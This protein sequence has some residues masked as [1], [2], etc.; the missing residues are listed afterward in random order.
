MDI[1]CVPVLLAVSPFLG[2][3]VGG[4]QGL[5]VSRFQVVAGRRGA[6]KI[7]SAADNYVFAAAG[8][9]N[10]G[11]LLYRDVQLH[12]CAGKN[13]FGIDR[14]GEFIYDR[15]MRDAVQE[16]GCGFG[17]KSDVWKLYVFAGGDAGVFIK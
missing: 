16:N 5:F 17:K 3:C 7:Y 6:N 4:T 1:V 11:A 9:C 8:A 12:G 13:K 14:A 2:D 15:K 10:T